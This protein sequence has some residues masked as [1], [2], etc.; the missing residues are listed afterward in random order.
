MARGRTASSLRLGARR[1][2]AAELFTKGYSVVEVARELEVSP[3]TASRY[4]KRFEQ[5]IADQARA[6]PTM[7]RNVVAN[8]MRALEELE[9]VREA[10]WRRHD[11]ATNDTVRASMLKIVLQAQD[12]RA[13]LFGL[14]GVKADYFLHVA[15]VREQQEKLIEYMTRHLCPAD[16]VKLEEFILEQF[17][18]ELADLPTADRAD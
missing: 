15:A 11:A 7:L 10:A 16:R 14:F 17:N 8:T 4:K 2:K 13:K 18:N 1:E 12:Q 3:D 9:K 6:N 5:D